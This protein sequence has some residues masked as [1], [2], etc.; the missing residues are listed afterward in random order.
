MTPVPWGFSEMDA[1]FVQILRERHRYALDHKAG[2][3][4]VV[5][6]YSALVPEE[7]LWACGVLPVQ[8]LVSPG[9]Y[10]AAQSHLPAYVCDCAKSLLEQVLDG[11]YRYLDG[12]LLPHVCE[13]IR[14]LA[15]IFSMNL[16]GM[17]VRGSP[18]P[19]H[20]DR[21]ARDYLRAEFTA[22]A[23]ELLRRGALA[24]KEERL[25]EAIDLYNE[26][27]RLV[28][29]LY[30][31]RGR[32]PG[33][34][35]PEQVLAAVL[36]GG[37][38]PKTLHNDLLSAFLNT[39][40]T[41]QEEP[42]PRI[43]LSG[44]LFENELTEK[45]ALL[46]ILRDHRCQV[47]WDDL[48]P[49]MRYRWREVPLREDGDLLET[50]IEGYLGSQAAPLRSPTERRAR[51]LLEAAKRFGGQGMILLVPK[52]CDPMLFEIQALTQALKDQGYPVLCLE[53]SGTLSEGS[54]RTRVEA[55]IEM[56]SEVSELL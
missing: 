55:F 45:S 48:A 17:F 44:L 2:G 54:L 18:A 22:L 53:I 51:G 32:T 28:R 1:D 23:E 52:Y 49:G 35:P 43:L 25:R 10:V 24:L 6:C 34:V 41:G 14:G 13:T 46:S 37:I 42:G 29:R 7:L 19:L 38:M 31:T 20:T 8:L 15:G 26:N 3:G 40:R 50:L 9:R 47:V 16:E 33:S 56:I 27:R 12:V 36:A 30:E 39:L 21:G 4:L 11:T 5:G